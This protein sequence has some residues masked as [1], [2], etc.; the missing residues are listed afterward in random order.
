MTI[1]VLSRWRLRLC[2]RWIGMASPSM[3]EQYAGWRAIEA[4][5][6]MPTADDAE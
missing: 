2:G 1:S 3:G 5:R 4:S 6:P